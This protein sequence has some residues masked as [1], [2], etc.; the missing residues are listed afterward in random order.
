MTPWP[1]RDLLCVAKLAHGGFISVQVLSVQKELR[2]W[3]AGKADTDF[4]LWQILF[5]FG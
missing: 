1:A 2:R 4:T 5:F 3:I